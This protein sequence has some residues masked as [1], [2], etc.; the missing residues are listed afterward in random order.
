MS[1]SSSVS[2]WGFCIRTN[3]E[4]HL[5]QKKISPDDWHSKTC[6]FS[7]CLFY[8]QLG[9]WKEQQSQHQ[10]VLNRNKNRRKAWIST[11]KYKIPFYTL[12]LLQ[13][14]TPNIQH[15]RNILSY[16]CVCAAKMMMWQMTWLKLLFNIHLQINSF[17]WKK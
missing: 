1:L 10:K 12:S 14:L 7:N 2:Q 6:T 13:S 4:T 11:G 5:I 16:E 17:V 8:C 9:W 3:K 15:E